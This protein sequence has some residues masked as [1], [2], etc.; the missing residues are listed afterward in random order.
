MNKSGFNCMDKEIFKL[1]YPVLVRPLLKY[2]V[3]IWTPYKQK[4]IDLIEGVQKRAVKLVP[5]MKVGMREM[6]Y[7]KKLVDLKLTRLVERRFRGEMIETYK[8]LNNKEGVNPGIFFK[9]NIE[10]RDAELNH[11]LVIWKPRSSGRARR[12]NTFSQRIVNPWKRL[13]REEVQ[14]IKISVF[15]AKFDLKKSK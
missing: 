6:T 11:G 7:D 12:R 8:I 14:A 15:K 4:Y 9:I 10:R 13:S 2:C 5:G 3:Q 1:V